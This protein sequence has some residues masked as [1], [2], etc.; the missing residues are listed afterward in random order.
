LTSAIALNS[1]LW[2]GARILGPLAAAALIARVGLAVCF[3]LNG[4]SFVAVL[5]ALARIRVAPRPVDP[6][7][8]PAIAEGLRF[9]WEN[10]RAFRVLAL[11]AVTACFGWAYQTLLP[12]LA[13]ERFGRGA[14]GVGALMAAAGGGS[15]LACLLTAAL[16][17]E[18]HRRVLVYGGA[19]LYG[20]ALALFA[21]VPGY[22]QALITIAVVGFGLIVCGVNINAGLQEWVP[23]QLRGR[24]MAIFSL[25]F[26]GLQPLG[27]LLA[28]FAAEAIGSAS[29]LRVAAAVCLTA[30]TALFL[31]SQEDEHAAARS[32]LEVALESA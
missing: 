19:F 20:S 29:T 23:D 4:L 13:H 27:G 2:N 10:P 5:F 7:A 25:L 16:P 11:F 24:V 31:W 8:R 21:G 22:A 14:D 32:R 6:A 30:T 17:Q 1:M 28:G 3:L 15:I 18:T 26:M 9:V 12:A